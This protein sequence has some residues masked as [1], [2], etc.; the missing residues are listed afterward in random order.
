M[1]KALFMT[2][3]TD[4]ISLWLLIGA[5]YIQRSQVFSSPKAPTIRKQVSCCLI[6]IPVKG[7]LS[8]TFLLSAL[9]WKV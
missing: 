7:D 4:I 3:S 5:A 9:W 8:V 1:Q 6:T 2:V